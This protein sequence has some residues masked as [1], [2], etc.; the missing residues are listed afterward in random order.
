MDWSEGPIIKPYRPREGHEA[1]MHRRLKEEEAVSKTPPLTD[2]QNI[3]KSLD[4][5]EQKID[6]L[7]TKGI[8]LV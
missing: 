7:L 3:I 8:K 6:Q 1:Y 4:R 2:T 5:I